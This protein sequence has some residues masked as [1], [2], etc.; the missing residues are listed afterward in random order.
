MSLRGQSSEQE[1][2]MVTLIL[3]FFLWVALFSTLL[4][5]YLFV[6][7]FMSVA[8]ISMKG[9]LLLL[10]ITH[11]PNKEIRYARYFKYA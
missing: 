7:T 8:P 11:K 4:Q 2:S 10:P 3:F 5:A 6:F 9:L 1:I